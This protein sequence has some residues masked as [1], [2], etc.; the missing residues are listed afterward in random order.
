[1][2]QKDTENPTPEWIDMTDATRP[3]T[4]TPT[5][6]EKPVSGEGNGFNNGLN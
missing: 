3:G 6:P 5:E 1:M 4:E 2:A